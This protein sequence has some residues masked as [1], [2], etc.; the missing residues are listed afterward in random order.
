M[1]SYVLP[2]IQ[3]DVEFD[4]HCRSGVARLRMQM[5]RPRYE[6]LLRVAEKKHT[7]VHDLT[8]RA[9]ARELPH[10]YRSLL[11]EAPR[12]G[13]DVTLD[14]DSARVELVL[15]LPFAVYHWLYAETC[16]RELN[17]IPLLFSGRLLANLPRATRMAL[18]FQR[19]AVQ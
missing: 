1:P 14:L 19:G 7:T 8:Y 17:H 18:L 6:C 10:A 9:I 16:R 2:P 5:T 15:V 11:F 12:P 4:R 3:C 13:G